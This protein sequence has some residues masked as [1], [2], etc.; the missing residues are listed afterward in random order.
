M[1]VAILFCNDSN[2]YG[3]LE[4]L[5]L[6]FPKTSKRSKMSHQQHKTHVE[7]HSLFPN[8]E[9]YWNDSTKKRIKKYIIS[10]SFI[11]FWDFFVLLFLIQLSILFYKSSY[12]YLYSVQ[13]AFFLFSLTS[14]SLHLPSLNPYLFC[15]SHI[16]LHL[17]FIVCFRDGYKSV[18]T[19]YF[20]HANCS[21]VTVSLHLPPK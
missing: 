19:G 15:C 6:L 4:R 11:L 9:I 8:V 14:I 3:H 18:T 21:L 16:Q 5:L 7:S 13:H 17:F 2:R 10:F 12:L 1:F 20:Q